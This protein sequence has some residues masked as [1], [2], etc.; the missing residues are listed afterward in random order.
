MV[1]GPLVPHSP[2][3]KWDSGHLCSDAGFIQLYGMRGCWVFTCTGPPPRLYC[4]L[5]SRRG[6]HKGASVSSLFSFLHETWRFNLR[7]GSTMLLGEQNPSVCPSPVHR[8]AEASSRVTASVRARVPGC[9][10]G[11]CPFHCCHSWVWRSF[12]P[13]EIR[14]GCISLG[15]GTG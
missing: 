12:L 4:A 13:L 7:L 8:R 9:I 6:W 10:P 11:P 1:T 2:P 15:V 3:V 14:L 5:G